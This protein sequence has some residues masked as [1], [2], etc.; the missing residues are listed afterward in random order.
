MQSHL[1]CPACVGALKAYVKAIEIRRAAL[2]AS[3]AAECSSQL[4]AR[5]LNNA[6]V[7][8]LRAGNSDVSYAL[9]VEAMQAAG[10][11][12]LEGVSSLAQVKLLPAFC[13]PGDGRRVL[14]ASIPMHS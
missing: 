3:L 12:G 4:P 11:L 2:Q 1:Q 10:G 5:L 7:L 14:A 13:C 9:M 6:A 8:H